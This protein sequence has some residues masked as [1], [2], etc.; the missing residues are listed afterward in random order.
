MADPSLLA[1][2]AA[3]TGGRFRLGAH[4]AGAN[5]IHIP[6]IRI[7]DG[8]CS[9]WTDLIRNQIEQQ[10]ETDRQ[11]VV[12][13]G[14]DPGLRSITRADFEATRAEGRMLDVRMV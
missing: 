10:A 13:R 4:C 1:G 6:V 5:A 9:N 2:M 11:A 3:G 14:L 7:A 8:F 12:G